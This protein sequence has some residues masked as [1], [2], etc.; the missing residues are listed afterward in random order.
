MSSRRARRSPSGH[1][2][3]LQLLTSVPVTGFGCRPAELS[4]RTGGGIRKP[5]GNETAGVEGLSAGAMGIWFPPTVQRR[6]W[7]V[8]IGTEIWTGDLGTSIDVAGR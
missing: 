3:L 5:P 6:A 4:T 1:R 2:P 8:D 7:R